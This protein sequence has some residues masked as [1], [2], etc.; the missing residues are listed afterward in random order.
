MLTQP[1]AHQNPSTFTT[2]IALGEG[3]TLDWQPLPTISIAGSHHTSRTHVS[4]AETSRLRFSEDIQLRRWNESAGTFISAMRIERNGAPIVHNTT[5]L[6]AES[7]DWAEN[8]V[9]K[10]TRRFHTTIS[11]LNVAANRSVTDATPDHVTTRTSEAEGADDQTVVG[12]LSSTQVQIEH[13]LLSVSVLRETNGEGSQP[14][15]YP[16]WQAQTGQPL[17]PDFGQQ[18]S[19][20]CRP[21]H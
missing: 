11:S 21:E 3:A 14:R 19:Y 6:G 4:L 16:S 5:H 18:C 13:L 12:D 10:P 8:A 1:D 17:G 15:D 9:G 20:C 2:T 7:L